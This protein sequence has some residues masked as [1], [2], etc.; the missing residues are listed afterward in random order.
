MTISE[1]KEEI[2]LLLY[3]FEVENDALIV[4]IEYELEIHGLP[5][6]TQVSKRK[7][8]FKIQ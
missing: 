4:D 8:V 2:D 3:R 6:K 1:L 5:T 7:I